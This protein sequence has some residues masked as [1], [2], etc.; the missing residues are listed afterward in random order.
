MGAAKPKMK[1]HGFQLAQKLGSEKVIINMTLISDSSRQHFLS[2]QLLE[3]ISLHEAQ[4]RFMGR[5]WTGSGR[6]QED[7]LGS[8]CGGWGKLP[9]A[10]SV[11]SGFGNDLT[12]RNAVRCKALP[13]LVW[14]TL[15][16]KPSTGR[17]SATMAEIQ[18]ALYGASCVSLSRN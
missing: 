6:R 4:M 3:C 9:D 8:P 1:T 13:S 14:S 11:Q 10:W 17:C 16:P 7:R 18:G 15:C 12:A 5:S 2:S